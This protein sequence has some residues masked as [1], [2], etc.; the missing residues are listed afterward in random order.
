MLA[1]KFD[2]ATRCCARDLLAPSP[3]QLTIVRRGLALTADASHNRRRRFFRF[4]L[5]AAFAAWVGCADVLA[6]EAASL[7]SPGSESARLQSQFRLT[8]DVLPAQFCRFVPCRSSARTVEVTD[9]E[10]ETSGDDSPRFLVTTRPNS[11]TLASRVLSFRIVAPDHL[12]ELPGTP[13][14]AALC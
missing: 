7:D 3:S 13:P 14:P 1:Y 12:I 9:E 8:G 6:T 5:T 2:R 4:V 10:Q 11:K